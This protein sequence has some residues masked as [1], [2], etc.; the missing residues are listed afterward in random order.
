MVRFGS[1]ASFS[2]RSPDVCLSPVSG[3]I[4]HIPQ[5]PLRA[6]RRHRSFICSG[7][8][9]LDRCRCPI[10]AEGSSVKRKEGPSASRDDVADEMLRLLGDPRDEA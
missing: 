6:N 10:L 1:F 4:A 8:S 3:G 5:P 2:T 9:E 7:Q